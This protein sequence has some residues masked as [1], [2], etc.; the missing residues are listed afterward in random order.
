M[1]TLWASFAP[2]LEKALYACVAVL[3][4]VLLHRL[5]SRRFAWLATASFDRLAMALLAGG[6]EVGYRLWGEKTSI[7]QGFGWDG[8]GF[9]VWARHWSKTIFETKL[10]HYKV[11]KSL[12]AGVIHYAMRALHVERTDRNILLAF[13]VA[14]GVCFVGTT[15]LWGAIARDRRLRRPAAWLGFALL[16]ASFSGL[17]FFHYIP[18]LLDPWGMLIGAAMFWLYLRRWTIALAPL[19]FVGGFVIPGYL[20][21]LGSVFM[22]FPRDVPPR[23]ATWP[24]LGLGLGLG[25]GLVLAKRAWDFHDAGGHITN[26]AEQVV[27][28]L[29]PLSAAAL[30]LYVGMSL[31]PLLARI[32]TLRGAWS[33]VRLRWL[34]VIAGIAWAIPKIVDRVATPVLDVTPEAHQRVVLL[35]AI[36]R[37]LASVVASFA[38]FGPLILLMWLLRKPIGELLWDLGPGAVAAYAALIVLGIDSESRHLMLLL[39]VGITAVSLAFDR[40]AGGG[41]GW[42]PVVVACLGIVASR[43]WISLESPPLGKLPDG[44][45]AWPYPQWTWQR[46]FMNLGPWMTLESYAYL[47]AMGVVCLLVL[48]WGLRRAGVIRG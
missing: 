41:H 14:M 42:F 45:N 39:P 11:Q 15:L 23:R 32:P 2:H 28:Q 38:F 47:G 48:R 29:V 35:T 3:A 4:A 19:A 16:Y 24:W 30:A 6:Y 1:T 40:R 36:A 18:P 13:T 10:D 26:D 27:P 21:L 31:G 22:F 44:A 8:Q 37:P 7:G 46:F 34:P 33:S 25:L 9:L 43:A 20:P 5:L 17:R 12:P